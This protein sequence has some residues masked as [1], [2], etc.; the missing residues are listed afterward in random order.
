MKF[1]SNYIIEKLSINRNSTLPETCSIKQF[2]NISDFKKR[3]ECKLEDYKLSLYGGH[4]MTKTHDKQDFLCGWSFIEYWDKEDGGTEDKSEYFFIVNNEQFDCIDKQNK[5]KINEEKGYYEAPHWLVDISFKFDIDLVFGD[6][7]DTFII[8]IDDWL[9]DDVISHTQN[10]KINK[11]MQE[12]QEKLNDYHNISEKL[13]INKNSAIPQKYDFEN[14]KYFSDVYEKHIKKENITVI[15][16]DVFSGPSEEKSEFLCC[17]SLIEYDEY[18]KRLFILVNDNSLEGV[19]SKREYEEEMRNNEMGFC[20]IPDWLD[21]IVDEYF[22][23]T[24]ISDKIIITFEDFLDETT[25]VTFYDDLK[26][27]LTETGKKLL[28]K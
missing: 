10:N 18:D 28:D 16:G 19:M 25:I 3:F 27:P 15:F 20:N 22:Y 9:E 5:L 11:E 4:V 8:C 14:I 26:F 2:E 7:F 21:D 1:L 6:D 17:Y 12:L 24:G 13:L 23:H